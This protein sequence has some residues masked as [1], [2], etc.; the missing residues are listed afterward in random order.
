MSD[1]HLLDIQ[2][3]NKITASVAAAILRIEG[4]TQSR[5]WAWRVI[6]GKEPERIPGPDCQRGLDHEEDAISSLEAELGV[7][8]RPGRFVCHPTIPWLGASP[9]SFLL[10]W[11][12]QH[13]ASRE[14]EIPIEAKCPRVL[15][16]SVPPMYYCQM[17][18]QLECCDAPHGYFVSWTEEGQWVQKV[19]RDAAWWKQHYP[20]LEWFY[21]EY[22][23]R[24]VEPPRSERRSK[25]GT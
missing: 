17:Q 4:C 25:H 12:M 21:K 23:E 15:H 6:T 16:A 22:V 14:I 24:D 18:I 8:A 5:K 7:L 20:T 10:E 9:D 1:D 19:M 2:R 11:V 13:A 3:F